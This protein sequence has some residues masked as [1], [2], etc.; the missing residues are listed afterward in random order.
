MIKTDFDVLV[1]DTHKGRGVF[2]T[3]NFQKGEVIVVGKPVKVAPER[4]RHSVQMKMNLHVEID[5]P[6]KLINHSC[7]PNTGIKN[8][9]FGAYD[10]IALVDIAEGEELSWDYETTEYISI[11]VPQCSCNAPNCRGGLRGF[12]F[13]PI[14]IKNKYGEFIA[15][16]LK[17]LEER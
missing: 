15:D 17:T 3:R 7:N 10:F 1:K 4:T 16:Y 9:S 12:S 13:R 8:N 2:A 14:E 5:A 6:A 11:S